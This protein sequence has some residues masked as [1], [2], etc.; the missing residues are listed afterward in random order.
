MLSVMMI[1][2]GVLLGAIM[3]RMGVDRFVIILGILVLWLAVCF[4]MVYAY[5]RAHS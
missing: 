3:N 4:E 2:Q 5:D 1:L